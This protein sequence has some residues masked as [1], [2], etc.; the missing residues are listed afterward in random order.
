MEENTGSQDLKR[1]SVGSDL[2]I[3]IAALIFTIYYFYTII[4]A[5]WTAQVAAFLVGSILII[6][7]VLFL[8]KCIRLLN[9]GEG[10][11]NFDT[12]IRPKSYL[13]KRLGLLGL[14]IA[15]NFFM[16]GL[17]VSVVAYI[18]AFAL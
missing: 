6:L 16:Y 13:T 18:I 8:V 12:L 4:N 5:P 10:A 14:T 2:I 7:V 15:Y 11:L 1:E 17:I 3:P 9:T